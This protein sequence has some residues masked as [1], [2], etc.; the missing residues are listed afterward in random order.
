M[1]FIFQKNALR[2][3][4]VKAYTIEIFYGRFLGI[5]KKKTSLSIVFISIYFSF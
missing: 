5:E 3:S 1:L 4:F 2:E